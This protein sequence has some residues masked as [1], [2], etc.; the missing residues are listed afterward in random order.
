MF[1]QFIFHTV[2]NATYINWHKE[3]NLSES[4]TVKLETFS[5]NQ[6]YLII[7]PKLLSPDKSES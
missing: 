5:T 4:S 7:Q 3:H 2:K 1:H 6:A